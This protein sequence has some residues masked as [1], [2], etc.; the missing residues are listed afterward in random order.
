MTRGTP[1]RKK[2]KSPNRDI[3]KWT[4]LG[5]FLAS[6]LAYATTMVWPIGFISKRGFALGAADGVMWAAH[7]G[8]WAQTPASG[9][10]SCTDSDEMFWTFDGDPKNRWNVNRKGDVYAELPSWIALAAFVPGLLL[11]WWR[12]IA[13]VRPGRC[14]KCRYDLR[15]LPPATNGQVTC[16]ECGTTA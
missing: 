9:W 10:Y 3:F 15:G 2:S 8:P 1:M 14:V 7:W 11:A 13:P 6:A 12:D 16:P 5:L 4:L